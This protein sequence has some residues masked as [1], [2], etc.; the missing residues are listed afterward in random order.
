[1]MR[2]K[3][4]C[5]LHAPNW[6]SSPQPWHVTSWFIGEH[7][8]TE[9]HRL[10]CLIL[11]ALWKERHGLIWM[12]LESWK[13][14]YPTFSYK[15]TLRACL[16]VLAGERS[17]SYTLDRRPVL[18]S[19]EK[20][21]LFDRAHSF[22]RD[23]HGSVREEGTLQISRINTGDQWGDRCCSQIALTSDRE[24]LDVGK[25]MR[26]RQEQ[27]KGLIA[28]VRHFDFCHVNGGGKP[29]EDFKQRDD[30]IKFAF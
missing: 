2:I 3:I 9:P 4:I 30:M 7:S 19:G 21:V 12:C 16:E 11:I 13:L 14:D 15:W 1:M 10:A 26:N 22:G 5:H 27:D 28:P 23:A 18:S 6:G 8:T 20:V 29:L 25:Q 17:Y 24:Q